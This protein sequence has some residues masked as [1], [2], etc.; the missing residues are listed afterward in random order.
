MTPL[1]LEDT[2]HLAE[3]IRHLV[4]AGMPLEESLAEAGKGRGRRFQAMA[5]AVSEGLNRGESL[6]KLVEVQAVGAPRMLAS[7]RMRP[8]V[9]A[10]N[11]IESSIKQPERIN[12]SRPMVT[13]CEDS[14]SN[15]DDCGDGRFL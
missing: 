2:Q 5:Q 10:T 6:Q 12:N 3:E 7:A 11:G 13:G 15:R 8:N 14:A 1:S 4:R 9:L